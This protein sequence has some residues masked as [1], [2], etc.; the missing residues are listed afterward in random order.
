[1]R[2]QTNLNAKLSKEAAHFNAERA[3]GFAEDH[4]AA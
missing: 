4:H 3:V 1:M 2:A